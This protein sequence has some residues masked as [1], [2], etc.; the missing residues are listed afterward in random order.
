MRANR[1]YRVIVTRAGVA[2]SLLADPDRVDLVEVVGVASG[3]V[4]LFW[5]C[6]PAGARRLA[7]RLKTD[8]AQLEAVEFMT[9]WS[10]RA[11]VEQI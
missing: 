9:R 7:R 1:A 5:D 3:E 10:Q 11:D 2:P 6:T 8:L 4:E